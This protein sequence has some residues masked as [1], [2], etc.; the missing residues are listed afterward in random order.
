MPTI[1]LIVFDGVRA[2]HVSAYGYERATTPTLDSLAAKGV[3]W[4][5]AYSASSWT[6]PS[7]ASMLTGLYP[8]SHGAFQGIK[9]SKGRHVTTDVVRCAR[10]TFAE[11]LTAAGWRCGAFINNAQLGDFCGLN[12]GFEAYD[13]S[14]GKAD[15]LIASF[16]EWLEGDADT[17][18]FAYLH[19]LEAHYPFKP[20]RRHVRMFGGDRDNNPFYGYRARDYGRL[21]RAISRGETSLSGDELYQMVQMY[22]GAIR[23][24]D[25]KLREILD[26]LEAGRGLHDLST[27]VTADH[28]EEFLDHGRIGH[29][30]SL[31]DELIHV[32]LIASVPSFVG[33]VRHRDAVSLVDLP[34]TIRRVAG[35]AP[36]S[37]ERDLLLQ[38]GSA[39]PVF[40]ELR[41]R[42]RY[43]QCIRKDRFKLIRKYKFDAAE[44]A[45]ASMSPFECRESLPHEVK[46]ELF[47]T[48]SDPGET[49]NLNGST[50]H[51]VEAQTLCRDLDD[52]WSR[53]S[54]DARAGG[55]GEVE[56]DDR[57]V[58]RLRDLG[59]IE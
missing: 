40:S 9:R 55:D 39:P 50:T 16:L 26:A 56:L 21:R 37:S 11:S 57:V 10:P 29:G 43:T 8:S 17:P 54:G 31:Y 25:G 12:R 23:R 47:D 41:I 20:R 18:T 52:W 1:L 32:P 7:V 44:G 27:F 3:L 5:R 22:D 46:T 58:Q 34:E 45:D 28:G 36:D 2:D 30:Q 42:N 6:K 19:F 14:A 38:N 35:L 33:G 51:D 13:S 4:E 48:S 53:S 24:L 49:V 59:Y 15:R